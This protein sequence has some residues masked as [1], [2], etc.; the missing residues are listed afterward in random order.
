MRLI[1]AMMNY[2]LKI[3]HGYSLPELEG[4]LEET[5]DIF[6][7]TVSLEPISLGGWSNVNF[8]GH[9]S[10]I[11]FVLKLPWSTE[12]FES[13]PYDMMYDLNLYFSRLDI[14]APP[15]KVGRLPNSTATPFYLVEYIEGT[16]HS[17]IEEASYEE[18]RSLKKSHSL[19][20]GKTPPNLPNYESPLG[21]LNAIRSLVEEHTWLSEAS[22]E[23]QTLL[24]N[25][26]L[27]LPRL[28]SLTD[29]IGNWSGNVMHGD[30]WIPNIVFRPGQNALFLDFEACALGD[31]RYDLAYLLEG[32]EN[33]ATEKIPEIFVNEDIEFINSLRPL[34][35][36]CVIDWSIA[37]LLSME[38]GIVEPNLNTERI[39]S[40]ILGYVQGKINRWKSILH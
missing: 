9:S 6:D 5:C 20:R 14:A 30:L 40:M 1:F 28:I 2:P 34:V 35:L 36:A 12:V 38:S 31:S 13:N 24:N 32:H 4:F 3:V 11:Q 7:D 17:S 18:L 33:R 10:G 23:T 15:L 16:T 25:Y 21:Y 27:I 8:R 19:L 39:H 37:R 29:A 22:K 26:E